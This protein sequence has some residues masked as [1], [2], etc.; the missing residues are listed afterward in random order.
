MLT[1]YHV[2][3][4]EILI[5]FVRYLAL[6]CLFLL[7]HTNPI[8][9][10]DRGSNSKEVAFGLCNLALQGSKQQLSLGVYHKKHHKML[11]TM[12]YLLWPQLTIAHRGQYRFYKHN[13]GANSCWKMCRAASEKLVEGLTLFIIMRKVQLLCLSWIL[14]FPKKRLRLHV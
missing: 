7:V 5:S 4:Q 6:I 2:K 11:L 1:C 3:V 14:P 12:K 8:L 9:F 10:T 13:Y